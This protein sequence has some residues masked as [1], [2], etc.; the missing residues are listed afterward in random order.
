MKEN[1]VM[2]H[3]VSIRFLHVNMTQHK[4]YK[5]SNFLWSKRKTITETCFI[6][7]IV[8]LL[9]FCLWTKSLIHMFLSFLRGVVHFWQLRNTQDKK[10]IKI[11]LNGAFVNL[12]LLCSN[13]K[14]TFDAFR[15]EE[16]DACQGCEMEAL[17]WTTPNFSEMEVLPLVIL[18]YYLIHSHLT[19]FPIHICHAIYL[20]QHLHYYS[21]LTLFCSMN[22]LTV[23]IGLER[24]GLPQFNGKVLV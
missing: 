19:A 7:E 18:N 13:F 8:P 4:T 23:W 17:F 21:P 24:L 3:L 10:V 9:V 6:Y 15:S 14:L 1:F 20:G 12:F 22:F 11:F 2:H 5:V 16:K